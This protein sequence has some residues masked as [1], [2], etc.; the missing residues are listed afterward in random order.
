MYA[1]TS[2]CHRRRYFG[3][4]LARFVYSSTTLFIRSDYFYYL[5]KWRIKHER[6]RPKR[7]D[8]FL[9]IRTHE[10]DL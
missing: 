8:Y 5:I 1:N 9:C 3:R 6:R 2:S 4:K 7:Y 10:N